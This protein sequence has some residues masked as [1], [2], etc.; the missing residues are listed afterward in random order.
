MILAVFEAYHRALSVRTMKHTTTE[1]VTY[2]L[3][4]KRWERDGMGIPVN[5]YAE[6]DLRV[7]MNVDSG[8]LS[9]RTL[10]EVYV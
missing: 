3:N 5:N 1:Y 4:S 8:T 10:E 7:A 6:I 2:A 9:L